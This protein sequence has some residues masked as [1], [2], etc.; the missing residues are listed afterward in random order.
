M[1]DIETTKNIVKEI[2]EKY[3]F[4]QKND[5]ERI[6]NADFNRQ[7][8]MNI[9]GKSFVFIRESKN[10]EYLDKIEITFGKINI[11]VDTIDEEEYYSI[12][13][14]IFFVVDIS[15]FTEEH[16]L[17]ETITQKCKMHNLI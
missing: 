1:L 10:N 9:Y 13:D 16:S 14:N 6:E 7:N 8:Y 3:H 15:E 12:D 2:A 4:L 17:I 11:E 5:I